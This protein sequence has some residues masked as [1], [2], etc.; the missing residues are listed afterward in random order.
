M[1]THRR[2]WSGGIGVLS[3]N[4]GRQ[5]TILGGIYVAVRVSRGVGGRKSKR[6]SRNVVA[7]RSTGSYREKICGFDGESL[8]SIRFLRFLLLKF[9]IIFVLSGYERSAGAYFL[10]MREVLV[11]TFCINST[12]A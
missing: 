7:G 6:D 11:L 9:K 3:L 12:R 5:T 4:S 8:V 2:T 10:Y 1:T